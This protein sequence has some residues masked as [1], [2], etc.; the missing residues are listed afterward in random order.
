MDVALAIIRAAK[1]GGQLNVILLIPLWFQN[2][3][4][5]WQIQCKAKFLMK[6]RSSTEAVEMNHL[7]L[8]PKA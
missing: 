7:A 3:M 6:G 2:L 5:L 8:N 4:S 1:W